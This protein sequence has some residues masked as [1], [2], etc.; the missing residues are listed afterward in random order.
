MTGHV[1]EQWTQFWAV[2]LPDGR[3]QLMYG[4]RSGARYVEKIA[5]G[6]HSEADALALLRRTRGTR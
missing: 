2:P 3:W 4:V 5:D 6:P 1:H